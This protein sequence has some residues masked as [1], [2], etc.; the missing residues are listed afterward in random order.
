M[1]KLR[2][3]PFS[4][5]RPYPSGSIPD[6]P[7]SAT[8]LSNPPRATADL[9]APVRTLPSSGRTNAHMWCTPEPSAPVRSSQPRTQTSSGTTSSGIRTSNEML[10]SKASSGTTN[11]SS[12]RTTKSGVPCDH[13]SCRSS[14]QTNAGGASAVSPAGAPASTQFTI[15]SI[16]A[17]VS[18]RSFSKTP[19]GSVANQGGIS[20]D[21]TLRA[22]ARAQGRVSS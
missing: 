1:L 10:M 9:L 18:P 5:S 11:G 15:V 6:S 4:I 8:Q 2:T 21:S 22:I 14:G 12:M 20:R 13:P 16:S 7:P 3:E 17:S 19:L